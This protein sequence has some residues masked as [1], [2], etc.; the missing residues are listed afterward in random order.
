MLPSSSPSI[1][2]LAGALARAQVELTNPAKSL[3]ATLENGGRGGGGQT[4]RYAPLSAGLDIIRKALGQQEIAVLQTTHV[5][6]GG[7]ISAGEGLGHGRAEGVLLVLT[8]TFAHASG[9]W[10]ATTWPVCRISDAADPKLLGAALTYARR[11]SLFA[12]VG[13]TGDDDLDAP[14]LT[15]GEADRKDV[16][17]RQPSWAAPV[18]SVPVRHR[19]RA[20]RPFVRVRARVVHETLAQPPAP[21][22]AARSAF[23]PREL[24][25]SDPLVCL[26]AVTDETAL[27]AWAREA[28]PHRSSLDEK[29]RAAF[30][31]AF[32]QCAQALGADPELLSAFVPSKEVS[33]PKLNPN[34]AITPPPPGGHDAQAAL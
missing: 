21:T 4:Y 25:A 34:P 10:V 23:A 17:A 31:Q 22:P 24:S 16:T 33:E 15:C 7:A 26:E 6:H 20:D 27:L 19:A 32:L 1:A 3:T 2:Q 8:T 28:L 18:V 14:D 9:E 29:D 5:E 30:D 12:L 11:Y 13:I